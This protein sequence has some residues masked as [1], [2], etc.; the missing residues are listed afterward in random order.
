MYKRFTQIMALLTIISLLA[1]CR[2]ATKTTPLVPTD[3]PASTATQLALP[4]TQA[5]PTQPP[6]TASPTP[7]PVVARDTWMK[8][9]GGYQDDEVADILLAEDGGY[10]IA[11]TTNARFEPQMQGDIYLLRTDAAGEVL[12]EEIYESEGYASAQAIQPTQDGGLLVSGVTSSETGGMDIFLM[13][14]DQD[15]QKVW[16]KTFGGPLDEFGGAWQ[17][18]DGGYVL[19]GCLV[20]PNDL[21][22]ENPGV[23]GYGGFAGRS[24]IYLARVD[25]EGNELWSRSYGGE[26][27][28]MASSALLT[29]DGGFLILATIMYFP[30]NDDDIYLLKV[31]QNGD[32]VWSRTWEEGNMNG[33]EVI[34]T[35]DGN[36][37]ITG[38]YAPSG[39]AASTNY[40]HLFIKVDPQGDEIW[41][42]TFG[43]PDMYDWGFVLAETTDGGYI[44]AG[45][46]VK[47]LHTW[48]ADISL[49]KID[50][51]GQLVWQQTIET[52]THTMLAEILLHPDGGYVIAGSTYRRGGF[53][54]LL[55]KTDAD[56][57][58]SE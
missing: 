56:G 29:P 55:V 17:M 22:V 16:T 58:V 28:V 30:D 35:S 52:N 7:E 19:G 8:T 31:D 20:D 6:P 47:D 15:R 27:N 46:R 34:Q 1:G 57:I 48:D 18:A 5:S 10:F 49:V 37:L 45:D 36:Y 3:K 24:N 13:K 11:G 42:S 50:A 14:L 54:I 53:D 4:T 43:E 21:V 23:A 12:W 2:P 40:D 51:Q 26:N 33:Y 32:E 9:Y 44:V 39:D 38:S 25:A 41:T